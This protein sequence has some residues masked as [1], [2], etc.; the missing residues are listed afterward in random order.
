VSLSAE[1]E[2]LRELAIPWTPQVVEACAR[3]MYPSATV[4]L[5]LMQA[6]R[7]AIEPVAKQR[8]EAVRMLGRTVGRNVQDELS[9]K[10][11]LATIAAEGGKEEAK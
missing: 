4:E 3:L 5:L 11:L 7:A 8:D 9:R 2:R 6:L 10:A 1:D